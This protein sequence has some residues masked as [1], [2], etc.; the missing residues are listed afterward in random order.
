MVSSMKNAGALC[1]VENAGDMVAATAG[2]GTDNVKV[3]SVAIDRV[4]PTTGGMANSAILAFHYTPGLAAGETLSLTL[5]ILHD[6]ASGGSYASSVAILPKAIIKTG[7]STAADVYSINVDLSAY[8]RY[9]KIETTPDLGASGTDTVRGG[10]TLTL[11]GFD[12]APATA[13]V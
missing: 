9:L 12:V 13:N 6:D 3:T 2:A 1:R 10:T 5:S 7:A 8:K 11:T 4:D